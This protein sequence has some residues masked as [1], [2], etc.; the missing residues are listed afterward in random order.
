[1]PTTRRTPARTQRPTRLRKHRQVASPADQGQPE[2]GKAEQGLG[3]AVVKRL[4]HRH[5]EHRIPESVRC[6]GFPAQ[7]RKHY[8]LLRQEVRGYGQ[9][10]QAEP[11][12]N[13]GAGGHVQQ[14]P[15]IPEQRVPESSQGA[16]HT[17]LPEEQRPPGAPQRLPAA[18]AVGASAFQRGRRPGKV[19]E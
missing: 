10:Q 7:L 4:G 8:Q 13:G 14:H 11:V 5:A 1:M 15:A 6:L 16:R 9:S 2:R 17:D 3:A 12:S 19:V 18:G